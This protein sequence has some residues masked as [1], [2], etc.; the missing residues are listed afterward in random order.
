M[1]GMYLNLNLGRFVI[2]GNIIKKENNI[3]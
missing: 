1:I 3:K 2:L